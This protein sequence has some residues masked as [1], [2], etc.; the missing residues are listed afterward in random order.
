LWKDSSIIKRRLASAKM[1]LALSRMRSGETAGG[2]GTLLQA[3]VTDPH[4]FFAS[5]IWDAA[6]TTHGRFRLKHAY[7]LPRR[8]TL[9][10]F[11]SLAAILQQPWS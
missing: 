8:W 11:P 6:A 9:H 3:V 5:R 1:E 4:N 2:F 7:L 10:S